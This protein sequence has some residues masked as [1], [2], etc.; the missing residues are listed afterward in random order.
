VLQS[1]ATSRVTRLISWNQC[2][3]AAELQRVHTVCV[4]WKFWPQ[5]SQYTVSLT[6]Y[7]FERIALDQATANDREI[8]T[9]LKFRKKCREKCSET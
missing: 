8:T 9:G 2:L 7:R 1:T 4:E 5:W 3:V 6:H